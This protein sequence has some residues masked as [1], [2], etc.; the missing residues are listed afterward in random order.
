MLSKEPLLDA[1][2]VEDV[3]A[4]GDLHHNF[5]VV[6][7]LG[8]QFALPLS[9]ENRFFFVQNLVV[10]K[11]LFFNDRELDLLHDFEV[12]ACHFLGFFNVIVESTV[13]F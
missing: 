13:R 1:V 6:E 4:H 2:R 12:H 8:A 10:L 7:V 5:A 11:T 9:P 3:L